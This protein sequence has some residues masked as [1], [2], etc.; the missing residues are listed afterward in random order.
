MVAR[1]QAALSIICVCIAS[2]SMTVANKVSLR[3]EAHPRDEVNPLGALH[4]DSPDHVHSFQYIVSGRQFSMNFLMLAVQSVV[5]AAAV[6]AAKSVGVRS[7]YC[8]SP[9]TRSSAH[10]TYSSQVIDYPDFSWDEAKKW[11]PVSLGLVALMYSGSKALVSTGCLRPI[12]LPVLIKVA[13]H[14]QHLSI[15][16]KLQ[17]FSPTVR[18]TLKFMDSLP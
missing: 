2:L 9:F 12:T 3:F 11:S 13:T 6:W 8:N 5:S 14:Q 17:R 10:Q 15:P 18:E 4:H 7:M 1:N 16:G